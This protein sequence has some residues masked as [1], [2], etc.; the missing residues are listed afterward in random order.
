MWLS[1]QTSLPQKY[2]NVF[3]DT[4]ASDSAVTT[5]RSILSLYLF[6]AYDEFL[7]SLLVWLTAYR[8]LLSE[9]PSCYYSLSQWF[10]K[11][12]ASREM[13]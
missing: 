4:S 11:W 12:P 13:T 6:L 1:S 8:K 9:E 2:K 3:L 10:P 5:L 7:F